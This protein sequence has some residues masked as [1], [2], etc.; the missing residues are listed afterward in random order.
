MRKQFEVVYENGV[1]HPLEPVD[2]AEHQRGT[3]SIS[4]AAELG[5]E[6]LDTAYMASCAEDA[7][8]IPS[9]EEVRQSL[10]KI[11]GTLTDDFRAERD[12]R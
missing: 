10:A 5:E 6:W 2:I 3:V 8:E 11:P 4:D 12:E 1:F 9:L 7:Q